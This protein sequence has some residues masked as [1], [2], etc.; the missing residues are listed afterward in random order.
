MMKFGVLGALVWIA[1]ALANPIQAAPLTPGDLDANTD[2]VVQIEEV[3]GNWQL[4]VIAN[5]D[6]TAVT[7]GIV[8]K[9]SVIPS[10]LGNCGFGLPVACPFVGAAANP[11]SFTETASFAAFVFS[12]NGGF[13]VFAA[14]TAHTLAE[15]MYANGM[16]SFDNTGLETAFSFLLLKP[17][18]TGF[19]LA[20]VEF[21]DG[22]GQVIPEPS[23]IFLMGVGLAGLA[24][25]RR[26]SA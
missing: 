4:S 15:F 3:A 16:P 17:D 21:R 13:G 22:G 7:V 20:R 1:V 10:T 5:M 24:F 11:F 25:L 26:R 8:D 12:A 23:V 2:A 6:L 19:D 9:A 18:T 14:N